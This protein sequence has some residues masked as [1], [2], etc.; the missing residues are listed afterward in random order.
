MIVEIY[1]A[2]LVVWAYKRVHTSDCRSL[3]NHTNLREANFTD[4]STLENKCDSW[5]PLVA[6]WQKNVNLGDDQLPQ[7]RAC[8]EKAWKRVE[9]KQE[10]RGK[11][12]TPCRKRTRGWNR[13]K[14][15]SLHTFFLSV[16][17]YTSGARSLR[18]MRPSSRYSRAIIILY[19]LSLSVFHRMYEDSVLRA[20]EL[21][22]SLTHFLFIP[23]FSRASNRPCPIVTPRLVLPRASIFPL[24]RVSRRS[25]SI[26]CKHYW[27][28]WTRY[29]RPEPLSL[30]SSISRV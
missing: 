27:L 30:S 6:K 1:T 25:S 18:I 2:I 28:M 5:K 10:K 8:I 12:S 19:S 14:P 3:M 15:P 13:I 7:H 26:L 20:R 24:V 11:S 4:Y 16:Q 9:K 29:S 21:T 22:F 23:L 17:L